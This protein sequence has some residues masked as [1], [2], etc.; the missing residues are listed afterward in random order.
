MEEINSILVGHMLGDGHIAKVQK[1]NSYFTIHR[2]ADHHLYN[3]WTK[4]ILKDS[5]L[6]ISDTYP[7]LRQ[8]YGSHDFPSSYLRTS[9]DKFWSTQRLLWYKNGHKVLPRKYIKD[10]FNNLSFLLWFLDDGDSVGRLSTDS[11]PVEDVLFL[12]DFIN[13]KY[14]IKFNMETQ[15]QRPQ[16]PILKCSKSDK[17]KLS[18]VF[19]STHIQIPCLSYKLN[20]L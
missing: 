1:G 8:S 18:E 15:Y 4:D 14:G 5:N 11:F 2:K 7:K 3:V 12:K 16:H 20:L 9:R 19:K 17:Q 13:K 10:N 6:I